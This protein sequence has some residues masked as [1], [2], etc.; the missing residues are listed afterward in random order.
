VSAP[1]AA[2]RQSQPRGRRSEDEVRC[3]LAPLQ[4]D[5]WRL[6]L[7]VDA[8]ENL[9]EWLDRRSTIMESFN[10]HVCVLCGTVGRPVE[11]DH[12]RRLA[13]MKIASVGTARIG[14][15]AQE[16]HLLRTV[17]RRR[18]RRA[19]SQPRKLRARCQIS[20]GRRSAAALNAGSGSISLAARSS[21]PGGR[22]GTW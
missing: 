7:G 1:S 6:R 14:P 15:G 3:A 19:A 22:R 17:P 11:I 5:G 20:C 21:R 2:A 4:A 16:D 9:K 12:V 13:D 18:T 10:A 8:V